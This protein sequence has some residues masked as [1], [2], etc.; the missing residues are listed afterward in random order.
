MLGFPHSLSSRS[1]ERLRRLHGEAALARAL[2]AAP[3]P[4]RTPRRPAPVA[5]SAAHPAPHNP[6]RHPR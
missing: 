3:G 2:R 5:P 6:R 1:R 4:R